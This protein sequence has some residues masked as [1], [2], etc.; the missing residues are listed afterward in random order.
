MECIGHNQDFCAMSDCTGQTALKR[1]K[2]P[3]RVHHAS[4]PEPPAR[5][6]TA[7]WM[8]TNLKT[9]FVRERKNEKVCVDSHGAYGIE[10]HR[11]RGRGH[12]RAR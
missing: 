6:S 11:P 12:A 3:Y 9:V 5:G 8:L 4:L 7:I 1:V 2:D 10:K